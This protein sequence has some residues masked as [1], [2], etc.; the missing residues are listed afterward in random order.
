[1]AGSVVFTLSPNSNPDW[2]DTIALIVLSF[3]L[4]LAELA[5]WGLY[6]RRQLAPM[7][8]QL[9]PTALTITRG[10]MRQAGIAGTATAHLQINVVLAGIVGGMN[11]AIGLYSVGSGRG[12]SFSI[13]SGIIF[14]GI[15]IYYAL[16]VM[17]RREE[18]G[19]A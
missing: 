3:V 14:I 18:N 17:A 13:V 12:T 4:L 15:A 9:Q 19:A 2:L 6:K 5:A 1:V 10:E 11:L 8:A 7:L 16:L